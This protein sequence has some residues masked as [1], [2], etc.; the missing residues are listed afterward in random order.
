MPADDN[1]PAINLVSTNPLAE[2]KRTLTVCNACRYCEGYCPVFKAITYRQDFDQPDLDYLAQLC[3]Q[4]GA[5]YQACQY[6]PP[7]DFGIDVP[8][9]LSLLR[10]E[11][12]ARYA[13]PQQAGKLFQRNPVWFSLI[14]GLCL[15][16]L[17][18][19]SDLSTGAS[20]PTAPGNFY[21]VISHSVMVTFAGLT[22]IYSGIAMT[23]AIRRY[24]LTITIKAGFPNNREPL[25][26]AIRASLAL[27]HL[28]RENSV[29][30]PGENDLP[31]PLKRIYH[32]LTLWGFLLCFISTCTATA[33]HY[34]LGIQA[35]YPYLSPPVIIG[36]L[37]GLMLLAGTSGFIYLK[38]GQP[39]SRQLD[40][41]QL[42]LTLTASLWLIALTGLALLALRETT[43]MPALLVI[44][45]GFV[46]G[47]FIIM[48]YS[49]MVH[50]L[51]RFFALI[52]F[53]RESG[54]ATTNPNKHPAG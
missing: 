14:T 31:S 42:D 46:F 15:A 28:S 24:W 13:W 3:H 18:Y 27:T 22:F 39:R 30:C 53:Y 41:L 16:L 6:A 5:C 35:P 52:F 12:Y 26:K 38:L 9:A 10:T 47:F 2:A 25:G 51:F 21:D 54:S 29:G 36:T 49:K 23:L 20:K 33:Y 43:A 7:H 37:G 8:K 45:L 4:C 32:Q 17:M 48:P 19:I 34:I 11:N 44:H 1:L 50:G 40:L